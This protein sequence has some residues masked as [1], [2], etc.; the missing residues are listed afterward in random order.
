MAGWAHALL[1]QAPHPHVRATPAAAAPE[2]DLSCPA[3]A[4]LTVQA[5]A[6]HCCPLAGLGQHAGDLMAQQAHDQTGMRGA[7]SVF[8]S[9]SECCGVEWRVLSWT[10]NRACSAMHR[11]SNLAGSSRQPA[12]RI[13]LSRGSP[14]HCHAT[15]LHGMLTAGNLC[16]T[17][18]LSCKRKPAVALAHACSC[19]QG[20]SSA[21][22]RSRS[23]AGALHSKLTTAQASSSTALA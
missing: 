15:L 1:W 9:C 13:C 23:S 2:L 6:D 5:A 20:C 16:M 7:T 19:I 14:Q 12:A 22:E 3:D 4:G 17:S 21:A 8:A 11:L 18:L 10:I